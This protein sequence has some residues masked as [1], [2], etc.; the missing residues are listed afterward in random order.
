[1]LSVQ[2][3]IRCRLT[4]EKLLRAELRGGLR[5][6]LLRGGLRAMRWQNWRCQQIYRGAGR[7]AGQE[8]TDVRGGLRD[9]L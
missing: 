2:F 1:M 9:E 4:F 6:K 7:A 5:G 8:M 3:V